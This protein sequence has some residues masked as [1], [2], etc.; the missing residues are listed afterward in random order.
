MLFRALFLVSLCVAA[1]GGSSDDDPAVSETLTVD[2]STTPLLPNEALVTLPTRNCDTPSE[3]V[4]ISF[5]FIAPS[6]PTAVAISFAGSDGLLSLSTAGIGRMADNFVVRTRDRYFADGIVSVLVDA[7][8]DHPNGLGDSY[9][10]GLVEAEDVQA[11]IDWSRARWNVPVWLVG[12]SRGT[13]SCANVAARLGAAGPDG[14][15]LTSSIWGGSHATVYDVNVKKVTVPTKLIHHEWD[16]CPASLYS[17]VADLR[18]AFD[19][20]VQ[21]F[22]SFTGGTTDDEE[23]G[24]RAFHGFADLDDSVVPKIIGFIQKYDAG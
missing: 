17:G 1:C 16:A 23:C 18:A 14:L 20:A 2:D 13:I 22:D 12:T 24:A 9:R 10:T 15:V 5:T 8:S 3:C 19:N 21:G 7:P 6:A 11:I 4:T